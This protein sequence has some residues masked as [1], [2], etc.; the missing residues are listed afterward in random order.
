MTVVDAGTGRIVTMQPIGGGVDA[1]EYDPGKGLIY[2]SSGGDGTMS[3]FHQDTPEKY[4]LVERVKTQ[5]GARTMALDRKTGRAYLSAAEFGPRPE[6]APGK[7][8]PRAPML[9]GTFSVL[10]YGQ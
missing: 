7:K 8:Q 3:V 2:F 9:P 10:V 6:A 1:T 5:I 4:T